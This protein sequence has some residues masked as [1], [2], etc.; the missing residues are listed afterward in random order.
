MEERRSEGLCYN[1]DEQ[2]SSRNQCKKAI[3]AKMEDQREFNE[4]QRTQESMIS[5]HAISGLINFETIKLVVEINGCPISVLIHLG[6]THTFDNKRAVK[7][8]QLHVT[9]Q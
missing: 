5:L 9:P 2:Y 3:L 4:E 1:C 7:Q 8:L 6:K